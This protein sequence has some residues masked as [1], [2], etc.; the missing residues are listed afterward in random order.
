MNLYFVRHGATDA[1]QQFKTQTVTE[2]LN[3]EGRHQAQKLAQRFEDIKLDLVISSSYTRAE[4]TAAFIRKNFISSDLF[5]ETRK[6]TEIVGLSYEDPKAVPVLHQLKE[7]FISDPHWHYSDEENF[8]DLKK[9]GEEAIKF[10]ES[11]NKDNILVVP[12]RNFI[13]FLFCLF[14]F[15]DQLTPEI[16]LQTK[17]FI[18]LGNTGIS[19]FTNE[20]GSWQLK[21]WN[22]QA[23]LLE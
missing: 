5:I 10:L 14:L 19:I 13:N 15:G 1:H 11:Q 18:R 8:H 6:P 9:R 16:T 3:E 12:H 2:A 21:C 7:K 22:D 23:H 20:H 4:Q 17:K